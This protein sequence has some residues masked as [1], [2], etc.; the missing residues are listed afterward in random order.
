MFINSRPRLLLA[1]AV[2]FLIGVNADD[3]AVL[4]DLYNS[5]RGVAW[6]DQTN[7]LSERHVC[8]WYGVTCNAENRERVGYYE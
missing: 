2:I 7:W 5:M 1:I 4:E 3:R 8:H 6:A